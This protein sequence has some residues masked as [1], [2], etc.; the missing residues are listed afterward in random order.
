MN[1]NYRY[2][3]NMGLAFDEDR[4]LKK[5]SD[6]AK[7][8]WILKEMTLLKYKLEKTE[9]KEL[10]YSMDY[11]ELKMNK[12]EYFQLFTS[13][14]WKHMCSYG[15]YHFFS[16]SIGTVPIYTDRESYLEKYKTSRNVYLK[17]LII[18]TLLLVIVNFLDSFVATKLNSKVFHIALSLV[19]IVSA[20]IATPS[21][22][23]TVAYFFRFKR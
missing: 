21:L 23:V 9:A 4:V 14:G 17:A 15:P 19:G 1:N 5:F 13:S 22:M 20:A 12:D 11:K 2:I 7:E 3:W 10:I 6:L 8:G 16:A 18:S